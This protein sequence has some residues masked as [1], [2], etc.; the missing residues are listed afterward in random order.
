MEKELKSFALI[1]L[2][3]GGCT[4]MMEYCSVGGVEEKKFNT[5]VLH[6]SIP[7]ET[8]CTKRLLIFPGA[9]W[10]NRNS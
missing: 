9:G 10:W 1:G 8:V 7:L 5:P 3:S 2:R 6:Y 4:G